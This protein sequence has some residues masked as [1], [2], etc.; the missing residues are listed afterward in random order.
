MKHFES[1]R[2]GGRERRK[3]DV[4]DLKSIYMYN[5]SNHLAINYRGK[6]FTLKS[7]FLF[8]TATYSGHL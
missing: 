7:S 8:I 2:E 3:G 4:V 5:V 1:R 6:W